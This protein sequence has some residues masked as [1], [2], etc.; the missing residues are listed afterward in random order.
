MTSFGTIIWDNG[1]SGRQ[2]WIP[3]AFLKDSAGFGLAAAG[4]DYYDD[5][6]NLEEHDIRQAV[7]GTWVSVR[8]FMLKAA[9][10]HFNALDIYRE[11]KGFLSIGTTIIPFISVSAELSGCRVGLVDD[12]RE[13]EHIALAG[14]TA[15][16][17]WSF[18]SL[19]LSCKNVILRNA[20]RPGFAPPLALAAGVHTA[21]HRFGAQGVRIEIEPGTHTRIRFHAGEEYW[22]HGI[23]G[24]GIGLAT[25]PLMVGFGVTVSFARY[26]LHA[27]L[28]HHPVLGWS[29]GM[30]AEFV[31]RSR[32]P[33]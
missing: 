23:L 14:A 27:S 3:A 26:G 31:G 28:V 21:P 18:A 11:Q 12:S 10:T 1:M 19:S 30:G 16:V 5:M 32:S 2:P 9:Y 33:N 4:V 8:Q 6:D 29:K 15:W 7:G 22:I 25:N 17:P 20:R 13:R 24:L